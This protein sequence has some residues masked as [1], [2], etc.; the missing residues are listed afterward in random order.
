MQQLLMLVN[1]CDAVASNS[2]KYNTFP[3]MKLQTISDDEESDLSDY[4][5]MDEGGAYLDGTPFSRTDTTTG[6][7]SRSLSTPIYRLIKIVKSLT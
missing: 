1:A 6:D 4:E 3:L 7:I 5:K 2:R